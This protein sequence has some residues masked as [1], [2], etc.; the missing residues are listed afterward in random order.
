M[1]SSVGA[2]NNDAAAF[3]NGILTDEHVHRENSTALEE[4]ASRK[5]TQ[6]WC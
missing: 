5:N 6:H 4:G 2:L 3:T 1:E